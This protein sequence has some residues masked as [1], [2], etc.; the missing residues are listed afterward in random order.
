MSNELKECN[1]KYFQNYFST[2]SSSIK[3]LWSGIKN[4][5][6]HKSSTSSFN[7][8]KGKDGIITSD[9]SEKLNILNDF[10]P[11]LLMTLQRQPQ[12]LLNLHLPIYLIEHVILSFFLRPLE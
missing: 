2:N 9:L 4:I 11:I 3:K 7:K 6:C 10:M 8:I 5:I 1:A 12:R